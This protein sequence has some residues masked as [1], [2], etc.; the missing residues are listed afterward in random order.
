MVHGEQNLQVFRS[1]IT[2]TVS[3]LIGAMAIMIHS[4][5]RIT[6]AVVGD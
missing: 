1:T 3:D 6:T 2:T 5:I 4:T